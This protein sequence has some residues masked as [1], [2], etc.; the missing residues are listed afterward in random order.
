MIYVSKMQPREK[1]QL[2]GPR[3]LTEEELICIL[4]RSGTK[5]QKVGMLARAVLEHFEAHKILD[6]ET[7]SGIKGMGDVRTGVILAAFELA[8]R[9]QLP[10]G[11][12]IISPNDIFSL[13]RH[14]GLKTQEHF[15]SIT[16]NGAHEVINLRTVTI[17]LVNRAEI[18][19]RE[20]FHAA[21]TD[22]S[23]SIIVAHNHPSGNLAP[24]SSDRKITM[25]LVKAG[26]LLGIEVLDHLIV[27]RAG[28]QSLRTTEPELFS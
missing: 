27:S 14:F 26:R 18:H 5:A 3:S 12:K 19:P 11:A 13:V 7:L 17:G 22:K 9:T 4:L 2:F 28:F 25:R 20:V 1:L 24:S 8:R 21:I 23:C 6:Y 10:Q 15:V 16:L